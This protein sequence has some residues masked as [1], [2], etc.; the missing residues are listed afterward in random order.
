MLDSSHW[1]WV[2][3]KRPPCDGSSVRISLQAKHSMTAQFD[4][5]VALAKAA[6]E[7]V[8][9]IKDLYVQMR[10]DLKFHIDQQGDATLATTKENLKKISDLQTAHLLV[11]KAEDEYLDQQQTGNVVQ[12]IIDLDEI[13]LEIG[14]KLDRLRDS[15]E[16]SSIS[17]KPD[18]D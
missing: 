11:L 2:V 8:V 9:E 18:P 14:C 3:P 13:R 1:L 17:G 16:K 6:A 15:V 5:G 10:T 4:D 12:A 7:R